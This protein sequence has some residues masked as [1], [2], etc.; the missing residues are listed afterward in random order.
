MIG[1]V[2]VSCMHIHLIPPSNVYTDNNNRILLAP[3]LSPS[4]NI[5]LR[6]N[7][8]HMATRL[9]SESRPPQALTHC[10]RWYNQQIQMDHLRTNIPLLE[11]YELVT[12]QCVDLSV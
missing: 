12:A 8:G 4:D 1:H 3:F 10:H 7:A 2:H 5:M 11:R 9:G 6:I